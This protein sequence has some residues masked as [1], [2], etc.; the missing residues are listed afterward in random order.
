MLEGYATSCFGTKLTSP[1]S[2][3]IV[4]LMEMRIAGGASAYRTGARTLDRYACPKI[5]LV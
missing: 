4:A 3:R 1:F 2:L 5:S